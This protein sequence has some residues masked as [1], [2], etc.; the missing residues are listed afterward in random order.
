MLTRRGGLT[1]QLA[2]DRN[3]AG[4]REATAEA[5]LALGRRGRSAL[6]PGAG[7]GRRR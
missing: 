1:T 2:A 3:R 6:D 4:R 5:T 7:A